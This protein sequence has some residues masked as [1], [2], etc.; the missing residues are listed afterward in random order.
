M[1]GIVLITGASGLI[2]KPL[3]RQLQAG[4]Y[5]VHALSRS[6]NHERDGVKFFQWDPE[7]GIIDKNCIHDAEAV[8]HLAGEGITAKPWT[9]D[10][11]Q[12]IIKSRTDSIKLI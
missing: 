10:Q 8:I 3:C 4:G 9:K 7:K 6:E 11:K 2:G 5:T 1:P 12:K